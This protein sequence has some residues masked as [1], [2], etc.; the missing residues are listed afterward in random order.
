MLDRSA[1]VRPAGRG[2]LERACY[3]V[4]GMLFASGLVHLGVFALDDR[5][6]SGPLSWRKPASFGLS[7][8]TTLATITWVS[9]YLRMRPRTRGVLLAALAVVSVLEVTGITVQAWRDQPSHLNTATPFDAV[10]A[11]G[12]ALSAVVLVAV[13]GTFALLAVR[14]RTDAAPSMRLALGAGFALMVAGLLAG[15][16][17][18][19]YGTVAKNRDGAAQAYA[20][21]GF[22]KG[23]HAVTLHAVLVLP[24]LAWWLGRRALP[25]GRRVRWVATAVTAYVVAALVVLAVNLATRGPL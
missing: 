10:V 15:A 9:S 13:L 12:L 24:A 8:G 21:M 11:T 19:A 18:I 7:F 2:R 5:P 6:W 23:F 3:V 20:V 25:E 22:L 1:L 14:G 4:A 16:A 17:M